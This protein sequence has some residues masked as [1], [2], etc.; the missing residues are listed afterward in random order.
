MAILCAVDFSS[1]SALALTAASR[2]ASTFKQPLTILT[3][4]DPLLAAAEQ[5]QSGTDAIAVLTGALAEFVD[6]TLGAGASTAHHLLVT[7]GDP[8]SQILDRAEALGADLVVL[9]TQGASGV[10]KFV[11]GSVAER[12][13]RTS[14]RPVLVVPPA[15]ADGPMRTLGAMQEVLAPIDFH[16]HAEADAR[17][18]HRVAR[19]SH[20]RLRL[21]HVIGGGDA[22][23]W[24]VLR[25]S[26]ATQFEEYL[27][28][29]RARQ[30]ESARAALERLSES[31]GGTPGPTLEVV[32]G[33][34]A[35]Q[36]AKV[37]ER[38]DVDLI[39][40]GL[41]GEPGLLGARVGAVAYR[42]LCASPVAVLAV[43]HEA[44]GRALPFLD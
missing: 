11:F 28:G 30:E 41:R 39:V 15:V 12:V 37:A 5:M 9:A 23:R 18:A 25:Q 24:T 10:A 22:T 14:H 2:I 44:R 6:E 7:A 13:L 38:A 42:V 31:L 17:L 26:I 32:E 19:A 43:P 34:A 8:S 29:S 4:A 40:L 27:G 16:E 36:I 3:V 35:E 33:P 1:P 20:A 21:L